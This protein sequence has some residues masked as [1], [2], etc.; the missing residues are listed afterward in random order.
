M[1]GCTCML[2]SVY[3]H[4][5]TLL[6]KVCEHSHGACYGKSI[7]N[8]SS[9]NTEYSCIPYILYLAHLTNLM[10]IVRYK[11]RHQKK[12]AVFKVPTNIMYVALKNP[13]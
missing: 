9:L 5:H 10:K 4:A 7:T 3:K 8:G 1:G 2:R 13:A 12:P 11:M 6:N